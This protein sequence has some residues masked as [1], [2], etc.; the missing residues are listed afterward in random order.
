MDRTEDMDEERLCVLY[1]F[2]RSDEADEERVRKGGE[3]VA[4]LSR[5]VLFFNV[6]ALSNAFVKFSRALI[7]CWEL[8]SYSLNALRKSSAASE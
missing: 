6:S 4:T 5:L 1:K 2:G 8:F 7:F 3:Y